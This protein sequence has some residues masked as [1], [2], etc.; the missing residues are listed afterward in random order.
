MLNF[1]P[2]ATRRTTRH[3]VCS[4]RGPTGA[5]RI[6]TRS[7]SRTARVAVL[8]FVTNIA[9]KRRSTACRKR[10]SASGRAAARSSPRK[11]AAERADN[12]SH[13]DKETGAVTWQQAF[14]HQRGCPE[15]NEYGTASGDDQAGLPRQ[16]RLDHRE[17]DQH[18]QGPEGARARARRTR[19]GHRQRAPGQRHQLGVLR[20]RRPRQGRRVQVGRR[21]L[22]FVASGQNIVED[23]QLES[24]G[25][26]TFAEGATNPIVARDGNARCGDGR[27]G[28][29][30]V[31]SSVT[32]PRA[33]NH[34]VVSE[35]RGD[36]EKMEQNGF[37]PPRRC[38]RA[39]GG[40]PS[41]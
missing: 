12:R 34:R 3:R 26:G 29:A 13:V 5:A 10:A 23:D 39:A 35:S 24:A 32:S 41:S 16:G 37:V 21:S 22:V 17:A 40:P 28:A 19:S 9:P 6:S 2:F 20:Q 4:T 14:G 25:D 11:F 27:D 8:G 30:A 18:D 31:L 15:V 36:T 33:L 7:C 1:L 38:S